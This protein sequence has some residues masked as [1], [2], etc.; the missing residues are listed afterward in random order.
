M[1]P[2]DDLEQAGETRVFTLVLGRA[3]D[4][5]TMPLVI[6]SFGVLFVVFSGAALALSSQAPG[7]LLAFS[8]LLVPLALIA[9]W[10]RWQ[11]LRAVRC[12]VTPDGVE[13][14]DWKAARPLRARQVG[15]CL[16]VD[17]GDRTFS[18]GVGDPVEVAW[19]VATLGEDFEEQGGG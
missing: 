1:K 5:R 11:R 9:A 3:M 7:K 16:E 10:T 14:G 8:G 4:K 15:E 19:L 17:T 6:A 18:W 2:P 12:M 13:I